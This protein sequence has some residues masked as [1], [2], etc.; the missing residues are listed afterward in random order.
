[1]CKKYYLFIIIL[2][3]YK[4]NHTFIKS[5]ND[6][7]CN[8][9]QM[10]DPSTKRF[11]ATCGTIMSPNFPGSVQPGLWFWTFKPPDSN[12][13]RFVFYIDYVY[14]PGVKDEDCEQSLKCELHVY[15]CFFCLIFYIRNFYQ[16]M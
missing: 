9:Y 3:Q 8:V 13:T 5:D 7:E 1:M 11:E 12:L 14:G 15:S 10:D 4:S 6:E 16:L 2:L